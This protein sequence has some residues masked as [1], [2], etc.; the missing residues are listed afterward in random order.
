MSRIALPITFH[1]SIATLHYSNWNFSTEMSNIWFVIR[2]SNAVQ[3]SGWILKGNEN[4]VYVYLILH[5]L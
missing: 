1:R 4:I 3:R 5:D 2:I